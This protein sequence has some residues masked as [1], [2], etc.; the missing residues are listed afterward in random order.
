MT[1][2]KL[3]G[4]KSAYI[5]LLALMVS[6]LCLPA[7]VSADLGEPYIQYRVSSNDV[8][9]GKSGTVTVTLTE[10]GKRDYA[11]NIQ[12]TAYTNTP[13]VSFGTG[14]ISMLKPGASQSTSFPIYTSSTVKPGI[15]VGTLDIYYEETGAMGI[16]TYNHNS[17][18]TFQ[19][20]VTA[21]P[22]SE[23]ISRAIGGYSSDPAAQIQIFFWGCV[24]IFVLIF[25]VC[26]IINDNNIKKARR[27]KERLEKEQLE[28]ERLE[29]ERRE[30]ESREWDRRERERREWERREWEHRN[31][32]HPEWEYRDMNRPN[33][34]SR[35]MSHPEW[36][37]RDMNRSNWER[38]NIGL[39]EW[40]NSDKNSSEWW[41]ENRD[42]NRSEWDRR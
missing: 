1:N 5:L 37:Y 23:T 42:T 32:G 34:E 6:A 29:N 16:G 38:S 11:Q 30:W 41:E 19:Y 25:I 17:K 22:V 27:E 31:M 18:G 36:E 8:V 9:A 35:N 39:P 24:V 40:D 14:K 12:I 4:I 21:P 15:Y 28:K 26:L 20:T 2:N 33:W 7:V 3:F 13:G 10:T